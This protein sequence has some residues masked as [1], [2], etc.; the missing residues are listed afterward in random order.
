[1]QLS[2]IFRQPSLHLVLTPDLSVSGSIS[3]EL[4]PNGNNQ[5]GFLPFSAVSDPPEKGVI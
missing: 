4:V 1:M 2:G 3:S 5:K